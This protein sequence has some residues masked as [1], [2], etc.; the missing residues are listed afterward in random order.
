MYVSKNQ[1][2]PLTIEKE[3]VQLTISK[4]MKVLGVLMEEG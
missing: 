4:D 3:G 1:T 2:L